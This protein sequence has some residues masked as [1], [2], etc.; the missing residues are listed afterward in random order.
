MLQYKC[1]SVSHLNKKMFV[2]I[3]SKIQ[4]YTTTKLLKLSHVFLPSICCVKSESYLGTCE[5]HNICKPRFQTVKWT[6]QNVSTYTLKVLLTTATRPSI[7]EG[8]MDARHLVL[9]TR[10]PDRNPLKAWSI[11][12]F[13]Y[14]SYIL[15]GLLSSSQILS[16]NRWGDLLSNSVN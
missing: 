14:V 10:K 15:F 11:W 2:K 3:C 12:K 4:P 7:S 9:V 16:Q 8:I 1:F 13:V 5:W 6:W